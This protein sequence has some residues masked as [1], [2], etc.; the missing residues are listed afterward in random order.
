ML[1]INI[2]N[3]ASPQLDGVFLDGP[4]NFGTDND[5]IGITRGYDQSGSDFASWSSVQV[6]P[7]T[8]LVASTTATG[9][10]TQNGTGLIR[11][12]D[13]SNP[14]PPTQTDLA[15][16][17]TV[18]AIGIAVEGN[19]ALVIASSG[20]YQNQ[21][22]SGTGPAANYG[23]TGHL[24]LA[25]LDI[26]NPQ[27]PQLESTQELSRISR[28][29]YFFGTGEVGLGNGLYAF[30]DWG[31][32]GDPHQLLV[33]NASNPNNIGQGVTTV[34]SNII[35]LAG[36]NNLIFATST[37]G[38]TIYQISAPPPVTITASVRAHQ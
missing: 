17:G 9:T 36:S 1:S 35:Q 5:G 8:L 6:A 3:P 2:S 38:L 21:F 26:S 34:P 13:T 30:S 23:L 15:I 4:D 27:N 22:I 18:Q 31:Q 20:G 28:G 33:F 7:N 12:V 14:A 32:A 10:D 25:T 37:D 24:V 16:P 11:V 29:S 19:Q